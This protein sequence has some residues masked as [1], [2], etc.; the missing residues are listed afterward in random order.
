MMEVIG[1]DIEAVTLMQEDSVF[2]LDFIEKG[3]V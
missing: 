1:W 2:P 3:V